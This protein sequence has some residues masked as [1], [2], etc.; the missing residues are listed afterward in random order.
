MYKKII[1]INVFMV[2]TLLSAG[3][4]VTIS[5]FDNYPT[6][7]CEVDGK[8]Y[9]LPNGTLGEVVIWGEL[10]TIGSDKQLYAGV[11]MFTKSK[12]KI[13]NGPLKGKVCDINH[14]YLTMK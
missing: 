1:G 8:H 14:V 6:A 2:A 5:A 13:L 12:V 7:G 10:Y 3:D 11:D 4:K 9:L